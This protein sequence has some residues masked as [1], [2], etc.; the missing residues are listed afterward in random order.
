[1]ASLKLIVANDLTGPFFWAQDCLCLMYCICRAHGWHCNYGIMAVL[2]LFFNP[3]FSG[4]VCIISFRSVSLK[5]PPFITF[6]LLETAVGREVACEKL[7][8]IFFFV[9]KKSLVACHVGKWFFSHMVSH[10]HMNPALLSPPI[11][12]LVTG[13][14]AC[15]RPVMQSP[16]LYSKPGNGCVWRNAVWGRG[17]AGAAVGVQEWKA[18]LE[19]A[20]CSDL[21]FC[22]GTFSPPPPPFPKRLCI[23]WS[24]CV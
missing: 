17:A 5:F 15:P 2:L 23:F 9:F 13:A 7:T 10:L 14:S 8:D 20:Y 4:E 12:L 18:R 11:V 19:T 24:A 1:M 6:F 22:P 3:Q 21:V 16:S